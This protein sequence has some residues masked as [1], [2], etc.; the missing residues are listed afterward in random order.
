MGTSCSYI[1]SYIIV[2][3]NT[4]QFLKRVAEPLAKSLTPFHWRRCWRAFYNTHNEEGC[5][6]RARQ[7]HTGA[8]RADSEAPSDSLGACMCSW[9]SVQARQAYWVIRGARPGA[10]G[11]ERDTEYVI[12][13]RWGVE[14][15]N[16]V[17]VVRLRAPETVKASISLSDRSHVRVSF[18]EISTAMQWS[19]GCDMLTK[20]GEAVPLKPSY[21]MLPKYPR[22]DSPQ[23][24]QFCHYFLILM[25]F[26]TCMSE[27]Q[28][29]RFSRL[30]WLVVCL[31]SLPYL[32]LWLFSWQDQCSTNSRNENQQLTSTH[33]IIT[34]TI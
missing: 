3:E 20:P 7:G 32:H 17:D 23:K 27:T 26:L 8:L 18:N 16:K 33:I 5:S 11:R 22:N 6:F 21:H 4:G 28:K 31:F 13:A 10:R 9:H 34:N 19:A 25:S 15:K 24:W 29:E 1:G 14:G 2:T 30:C 12:S